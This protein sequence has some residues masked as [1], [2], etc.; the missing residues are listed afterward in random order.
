MTISRH[1]YTAA[2]VYT[3]GTLPETVI[4]TDN[5]ASST[6]WTKPWGWDTTYGQFPPGRSGG[7]YSWGLTLAQGVK[8]GYVTR[9]LTGL[10]IGR[11]YTVAIW[12]KPSAVPKVTLDVGTDT[13]TREVFPGR[14]EQIA[15]T[16]TA[17]ATTTVVRLTTTVT[18]NYTTDVQFDDLKVIA[19]PYVLPPAVVP[20]QLED[21]TVTLDESWS[22]Y[23]QASLTIPTPALEILSRLDPRAKPRIRLTANQVFGTAQPL[24]ALTARLAA[25]A[26]TPTLATMTA[27]Y[28]A[29]T[30]LGISSDHGTGYNPEGVRPPTTRT[31]DLGI[32]SRTVDQLGARITLTAASDEG[33]LMDYAPTALGTSAPTVRAAVAMVLSRIDA[34]LEPGPDDGPLSADVTTWSPG[35]TA[36]DFVQ[37]LVDAAGL[38]LYCDEQRRW[39]LVKPLQPSDTALALSAA[40]ITQAEDQISRDEG[41]AD[42]Y[43]VAYRWT[44]SAGL[45]MVRYDIAAPLGYTKMAVVNVDRRWMG[46]GAAAALLARAQGRG[47]VSQVETVSDYH[48]APGALLRVSLP[49]APTMTGVV[50]RVEWR[51]ALD[52]MST[53][54]RDLTETPTNSWLA[55]PAGQTWDA[56]PVGVS[57]AAS[58][59]LT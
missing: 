17:T 35:V 13:V 31:W 47:Q 23:A 1:D 48:A 38:R 27:L 55:R 22:P 16:F 56:Q 11:R 40:T 57:W 53:R 52:D 14:W 42:A 28:A 12:L 8:T 58:T 25:A 29:Q 10:T 15:C 26:S 51:L 20:L 41:W 54:S 32:R 4:L 6:A 46:D 18:V 45:P 9:T 30:I 43:T 36:W 19:H 21:G 44:D 7:Q 33:L 50:S 59:P 34:V 5:G 3:Q 2:V 49:N 24:S 39:W 37:P